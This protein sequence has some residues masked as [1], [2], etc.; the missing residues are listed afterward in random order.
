MSKGNGELL[1]GGANMYVVSYA[2]KVV[3]LIWEKEM[4][5]VHLHAPW[6][7]QTEMGGSYRSYEAMFTVNDCGVLIT[8]A[9]YLNL[10]PQRGIGRNTFGWAPANYLGFGI[11]SV[12]RLKDVGV[13]LDCES[14][15][16]TFK[17]EEFGRDPIQ[18]IPVNSEDNLAKL[19]L[20]RTVLSSVT[21]T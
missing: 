1:L 8:V 18:A 12:R 10:F 17:K 6:T 4:E 9:L 20:I 2:K 15:R 13:M 14:A 11:K 19:A 16:G 3:E 7:E 5:I 21:A